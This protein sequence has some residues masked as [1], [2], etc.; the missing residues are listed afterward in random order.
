MKKK[1]KYKLLVS[2]IISITISLVLLTSVFGCAGGQILRGTDND[3]SNV[4][5]PVEQVELEQMPW[6]EEKHGSAVGILYGLWAFTILG[7]GIFLWKDRK[8][9]Q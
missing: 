8:S 1:K 9:K 7:C 5:K 6:N 2:L 4:I 3:R